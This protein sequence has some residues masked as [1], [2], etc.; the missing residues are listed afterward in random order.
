MPFFKQKIVGMR[1]NSTKLSQSEC[2]HFF[3]G[4]I[5]SKNVEIL[6]KNFFFIFFSL[7]DHS[8]FPSA[9]GTL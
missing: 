1:S 8:D 3:E 6:K 2:R 5:F 9:P 4:V 7:V